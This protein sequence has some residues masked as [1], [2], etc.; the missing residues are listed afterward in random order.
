VGGGMTQLEQW[1]NSGLYVFVVLS[2]QGYQD[3]S[4]ALESW[5]DAVIYGEYRMIN[6]DKSSSPF[7]YDYAIDKGFNPV[8][9]IS[10][11]TP[12]LLTWA[13]AIEFVSRFASNEG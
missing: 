4:L 7:F 1:L 6:L 3:S 12:M 9:G 5:P 8:F 10:K 2:E 11:S 13:E